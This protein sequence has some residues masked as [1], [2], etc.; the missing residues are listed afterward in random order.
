M[1]L[2][3]QEKTISKIKEKDLIF[4][5]KNL[6]KLALN[7]QDLLKEKD[8][9]FIDN[10]VPLFPKKSKKFKETLFEKEN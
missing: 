4:L 9:K 2:I 1:N 6:N 5:H 7:I 3:R 10:V 8:I